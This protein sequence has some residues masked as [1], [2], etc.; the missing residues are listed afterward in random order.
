[1][2]SSFFLYSIA[3][4]RKNISDSLGFS[5]KK[6]IF[7]AFFITQIS[8]IAA[9]A[10]VTI[11]TP[12]SAADPVKDFLKEITSHDYFGKTE[13]IMITI[14]PGSLEEQE[15]SKYHYTF[16]NIKYLVG[17]A[18]QTISA[19]FNQAIEA[20][21]GEFITLMRI[22]DYRDPQTVKMQIA[23]LENNAS[24]DV[25]YSDYHT[26]YSPNTPTDKADNWYLNELPEFHPRWLY[27]DIPGSHAMWR[28][29][30][31]ETMGLFKEDFIFHYQWEFWNRCGQN[32]VQFQKV[33]ARPGTY[34]FNYF[35]QKKILIGEQ[36]YAKSY[37]EEKYIHDQYQNMW[38]SLQFEE[39]PFVIITPSYKNKDW[40]KR[41]IDSIINQNYTN[42]RIIY[43]D[44]KS[45]DQT[46]KLVQEYVKSLG[47]EDR[48]SIIINEE[49]IGALANIYK[50]VHSCK[51][52]EI[53]IIVDGDDALIH[54]D[55]LKHLNLVYQDPNIWLTYGQFEW[56]PARIPGF[57]FQ[58]P[59][60][61]IEKNCIREYRWITT[62]LR[63]FYAGLF[64]KIKE[65]DL[66]FEDTFYQ[67]AWDL[68][69]MY[70]MVEMASYHIRFMNE[71]LYSY[72]TANQIND[73][74]VKAD[75]QAKID[76]F[77]RHKERY[78]PIA[79][80]RN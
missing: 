18:T 4:E 51:P 52:H 48:I 30:L 61:V 19:L 34:F 78:T 76:Y 63:T 1:M 53:C 58:V 38:T 9:G 41:N 7:L 68:G 56:F 39:K 3:R 55:V 5:M 72:N 21:Q 27:R 37:D 15:I 14:N 70:P 29:S 31:H 60:W 43:I 44:D 74:K 75:L 25:V 46:G 71:I 36:D 12:F 45:P 10:R 42:Y 16:R 50:A 24:L 40:Y 8:I 69:M 11:I 13:L 66:K 47:K 26:S 23:A 77:I 22:E 54:N 17:S 59:Y 35:D 65:E 73:N 64:H 33:H 62:H 67:A 6:I 57:V 2:H 79:D 49:N 28:K 20:A 80:W 32:G